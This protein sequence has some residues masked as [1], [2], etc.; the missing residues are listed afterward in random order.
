MVRSL[1]IPRTKLELV[2][3][4][5]DER[6]FCTVCREKVDNALST[7]RFPEREIW[8]VRIAGV[9]IRRD[10]TFDSFLLDLEIKSSTIG[11][12]SEYRISSSGPNHHNTSSTTDIIRARNV[13]SKLAP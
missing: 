1:F 11:A 5:L 6:R 12:E 4:K 7:L 9:T 13:S 10:A 3:Q 8:V 2:T